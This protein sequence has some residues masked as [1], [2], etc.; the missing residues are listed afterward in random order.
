MKTS[1][2]FFIYLIEEKKYE[3]KSRIFMNLDTVIYSVIAPKTRCRLHLITKKEV[4]I[5][6]LGVFRPNKDRS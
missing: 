6:L 5:A 3:K 2:F 1:E 4:N